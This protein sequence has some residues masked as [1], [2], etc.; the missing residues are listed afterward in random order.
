VFRI[1]L[2]FLLSLLIFAPVQ[3]A[4]TS[5]NLYDVEVVVFE[6]R[7]PDLEGNELWTKVPTGTPAVPKEEP[8]TIGE[9]PAEDS[10]LSTAVAA[11]EKSGQHPVLTHIHW[12]QGVDA[13]SVSVP[14]KITN[15]AAGLDGT[16]R[17]YLSRFL[18]LEMSLT[19][20]TAPAGGI[21]TVA[22]ESETPVYRLAEPRRI[23]VSEINYFDHP[24]F[25]A[26]VRVSPVKP[27]VVQP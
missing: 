25:G 4:T 12:Q 3:A 26:L 18:V 21:F 16:L 5:T 2:S 20:R 14:V 15:A 17:F 10:P 1:V 7:Q 24:K 22:T 23:K 11:L 13:K 27:E 8:L 6:N 19:L 9:K